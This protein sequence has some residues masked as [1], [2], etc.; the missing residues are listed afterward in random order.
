MDKLDTAPM[1]AKTW[2]DIADDVHIYDKLF[3]TEKLDGNRCIAIH[4][5]YKWNFVSRNGKPMYVDFDMLGLPTNFIYDGEVCS[6]EQLSMSHTIHW[7]AT[8]HLKPEHIVDNFGATFNK[9]NGMINKH[10]SK[11]GLVYTIFDVQN[12]GMCYT[13]RRIKILDNLTPLGKNVRILP[14]IGYYNLADT[15]TLQNFNNIVAEKLFIVTSLGGEG[16]MINKGSGKYERKRSNTLLKVKNNYTMDMLVVGVYAGNG[17]Y[18]GM[19]GGLV[20]QAITSDGKVIN[21]NVGTGLSDIQ[22][23]DWSIHKEQI[24]GKIV[25]IEYFAISQDQDAVGT[26]H[27]S[28]RFPRLKKIRSD[29]QA[30]ST[31]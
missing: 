18:D 17:K 5:G 27:Y 14:V 2:K 9:T 30:T 31:Y 26:N 23:H 19:I 25:E 29:K 13:D 16:L 20:C 1:L 3:I 8:H 7:A 4:D 10:S 22:R 15:R 12:S 24:I 21:C 6:L 11:D 28:L